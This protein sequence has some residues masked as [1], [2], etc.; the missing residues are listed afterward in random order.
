MIYI[1]PAGWSYKD[2]EGIVFPTKKPT[3]WNHLRYLSSFFNTIEINSSFYRPPTAKNA[4]RWVDLV[5][6][7]PN[8]Q[9]TF[10]LWQEFTH[11][12]ALTIDPGKIEMALEGIYPLWREN[13]LGAILIQF[14]WSFKYSTES[15]DRLLTI[16]RTFHEFP[17]VV[18]IRHSSWN[19]S[20][21]FDFLKTHRIGFANIDQPVIGESI[22]LTDYVT[23]S[24]GYVR[25][26][27]RNY[28]NWFHQEATVASRY[29]YLYGE[30][31]VR[32][33][34]DSIEE[35][36][37]NSPKAFMIFN[38][39]YRGQAIANALQAMFFMDG[40]KKKMPGD[41][42]HFYHVLEPIAELEKESGDQMAL[43]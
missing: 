3:G 4:S 30:D 10:K 37:T 32:E 12:P 11:S 9:F 23:S 39:H 25:L 15:L 5:A 17:L 41:L 2:W 18:E 22:P 38:N 8:F 43:F 16:A 19:Q 24:I 33:I 27:G 31:E 34:L 7:N 29:D 20:V 26:H 6:E 40:E 42:L 14:P 35:L 1:G 28:Q 13:R 21:F 36:I